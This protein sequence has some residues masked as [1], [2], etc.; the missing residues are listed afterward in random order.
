MQVNNLVSEELIKTV[1]CLYQLDRG[2]KDM[3]IQT[4]YQPL[5]TFILFEY[6]I[7]VVTCFECYVG[8]NSDYQA[9]RCLSCQVPNFIDL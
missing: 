9:L 8:E 4:K 2:V 5:V 7:I 3:N 1:C 6:M